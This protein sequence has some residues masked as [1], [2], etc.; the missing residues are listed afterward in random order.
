[1]ATPAQ[2]I[3]KLWSTREVEW[4]RVRHRGSIEA[5]QDGFIEDIDGSL[6]FCSDEEY[7]VYGSP[8]NAWI[9]RPQYLETALEISEEGDGGVYLLNPSVVFPNG[10]WEAWHLASWCG[11]S[12]YRSFQELMQAEYQ[13]LLNLRKEK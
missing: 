9:F 10:E 11:A 6:E 3:W 7:F 13:R 8:Q 1:M 12:R 4:Y 5:Y 2:L